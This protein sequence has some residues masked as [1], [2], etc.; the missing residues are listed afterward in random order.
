MFHI[1]PPEKQVRLLLL[2]HQKKQDDEKQ[3]LRARIECT[4]RIPKA[5]IKANEFILCSCSPSLTR[6]IGKDLDTNER[7]A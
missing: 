6:N 7:N 5:L 2:L 4:W 3:K 1:V